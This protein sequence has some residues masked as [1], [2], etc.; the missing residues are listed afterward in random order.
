MLTYRFKCDHCG[1][2]LEIQMRMEHSTPTITL[3]CDGEEHIDN[4]E[5]EELQSCGE[6]IGEFQEAVLTRVPYPVKT[7]FKH[8]DSQAYKGRKIAAPVR[9]RGAG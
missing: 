6:S 5:Y 8:M 3:W 4:Y 1:E 2:L 7:T 9:A